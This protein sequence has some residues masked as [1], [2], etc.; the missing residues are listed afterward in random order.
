MYTFHCSLTNVTPFPYPSL[1]IT[2]NVCIDIVYAF[3]I[4]K[5]WI[6]LKYSCQ[7]LLN[8][9]QML[10]FFLPKV[11]YINILAAHL[12]ILPCINVPFTMLLPSLY[13]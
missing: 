3:N 7:A 13:T 8:Y 6:L 4:M 9:F 2:N 1:L 5:C 10:H 12:S 11:R